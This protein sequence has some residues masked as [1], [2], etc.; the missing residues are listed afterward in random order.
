MLVLVLQKVT[1]FDQKK[2]QSNSKAFVSV[3][4]R[5]EYVRSNNPKK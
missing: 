2:L 1:K 3:N 5:S 4:K